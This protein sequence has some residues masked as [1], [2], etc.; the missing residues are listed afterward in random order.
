[1][2]QRNY[3]QKA[4]LFTLC[5][6]PFMLNIALI[7]FLIPIKYDVILDNLPFFGFLV[8]LAWLATSFLDFSIGNLTDRIGIRKTIQ[9]GILMSFA[10]TLIF[11]LSGNF[12]GM[13]LG[14]FLWGLSYVSLTIPMDTYL[15][16][17]F[18]KNYRGSAYG[19][20]YFFYNFVYALVPLICLG[21]I[22]YFGINYTILFSAIIVMLSFP[23]SYYINGKDKEPIIE[24]LDKI[25]ERDGL[26]KKGFVD[27]R[28][29]NLKEIS[30]LVNMF[31]FGL[32][33]MVIMIGAP[34][35]FF[36]GQHDL[37]KGAWLT[38]AFMIPFAFF[39]LL[40][41]IFAFRIIFNYF[42]LN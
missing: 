13:T 26:F 21:L 23:L 8:T 35:L 27:L 22:Q 33:F 7:D 37:I 20:V 42:F 25:V 6:L 5:V 12:L 17:V 9:L 34:L 16:S 1:M 3:K 31:L 30:L 14:I 32:W 2:K 36:H 28:K 38:F 24:A 15:F 10:G 4:L 29:M 18:P 11:A 19:I 41:G 39:E 40:F